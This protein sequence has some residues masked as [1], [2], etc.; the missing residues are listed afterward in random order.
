MAQAIPPRTDR[1]ADTAAEIG[2][3]SRRQML[4]GMV[5]IAGASAWR[6]E[7]LADA[8]GGAT[9]RVTLGGAGF[10]TPHQRLTGLI[11][12]THLHFIQH[13]SSVPMVEEQSY[14]LSI[15]G[16]V[17]RSL[18][19]SLEDLRRM[20]QS[21]RIC[22]L[23][24]SRNAY[25]DA[26]ES[27]TPEDVIG[28]MAQSEWTGVPLAVLVAEAQVRSTAGWLVPMGWD[29]ISPDSAIPLRLALEDGIIALAQN[30][31]QLRHEHGYP[32]RLLLPGYDGNLSV[33]WLRHVEF[34]DRP[35]PEIGERAPS[36]ARNQVSRLARNLRSLITKPSYPDVLRPG[37]V[38]LEGIAWS[39]Y[40]RITLVEV[41]VDGGITWV[42]AHLDEPVLS[43]ALARFRHRLGWDGDELSIL[44]RA[45]DDQG[46]IQKLATAVGASAGQRPGNYCAHAV[47]GWR[48]A[49][50]GR[51]L[52][53]S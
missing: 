36:D 5:G 30:G 10:T 13:R 12:P 48:I 38:E 15:G 31:E 23:E 27:S 2:M 41:S 8:S 53:L 9:T 44:S 42:R 33:K 17:D 28:R 11:T 50:D 14:R 4:Y 29:G 26:D 1:M 24:C 35:P 7:G 18:V 22:F 40:G 32:A 51:I 20:P 3:I 37:W 46:N 49:G 34:I 39:G 21:S 45:T 47:V 6:P 52:F 19:L 43:K 16:Q 25:A